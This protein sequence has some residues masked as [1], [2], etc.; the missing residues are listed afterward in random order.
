MYSQIAP[1][2]PIR[3]KD[4]PPEKDGWAAELKLDGYRGLADTINARVLSKN[5]NP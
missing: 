5:L 1:I 2:I 4:L 3:C